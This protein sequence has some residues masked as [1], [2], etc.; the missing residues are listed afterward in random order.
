MNVF[1]LLGATVLAL[2]GLVTAT[3]AFRRRMA[4]GPALFWLALW[5]AATAAIL[6]P[7]ITVV[8]A[9][10]LGIDRGADLV[11]YC[12]ILAMFAGFFLVYVRLRRIDKNITHVVRQMAILE[13]RQER[14]ETGQGD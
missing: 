9:R 8:V 14:L 1:Q 10:F 6:E 3:A 4:W 12:G 2:L 7:R 13:A 11:F 5:V